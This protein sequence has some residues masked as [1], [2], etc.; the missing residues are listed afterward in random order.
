MEA[1][2][3]SSVDHCF[4]TTSRFNEPFYVSLACSADNFEFNT[5]FLADTGADNSII[6][7]DIFPP[8]LQKFLYPSNLVTNGVGGTSVKSLGCFNCSIHIGG[9]LLE[10]I[11]IHVMDT[12]APPLLGRNVLKRPNMESV[13]SLG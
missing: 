4:R 2:A 3:N 13:E 7:T 1:S 9:N 8:A 6:S 12:K 5:L 10:N 11:T